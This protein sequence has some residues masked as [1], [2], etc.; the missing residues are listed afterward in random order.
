[1]D[2][3]TTFQYLGGVG[4]K[5]FLDNT[6]PAGPSPIIYQIQGVRTTAIGTAQEFIVNIGV[7]SSG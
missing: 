4:T 5:K 7:G 1:M 3:E 6:L 2:G